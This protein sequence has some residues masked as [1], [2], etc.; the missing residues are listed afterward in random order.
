MWIK[1][2][3]VYEVTIPNSHMTIRITKIVISIDTALR[4]QSG[5]S[6]AK[7]RGVLSTQIPVKH[8]NFAVSAIRASP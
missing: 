7:P 6:V 1:P 3:S 2:Y 5:N 4:G 8:A